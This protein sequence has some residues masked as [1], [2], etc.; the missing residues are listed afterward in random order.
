[1]NAT[2]INKLFDTKISDLNALRGKMLQEFLGTVSPAKVK[3]RSNVSR[4]GTSSGLSTGLKSSSDRSQA[5]H[6]RHSARLAGF[7]GTG[8]VEKWSGAGRPSPA[9]KQN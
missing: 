4:N 2:A 1:M 6:D 8:A 9:A 7:T 5:A 3:Q